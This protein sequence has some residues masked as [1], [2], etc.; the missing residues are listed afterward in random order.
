MSRIYDVK[1]ML[2]GAGMFAVLMATGGE[3]LAA[4]MP[5]SNALQADLVKSEKLTVGLTFAYAPYSYLDEGEPAGFD[6]ETLRLIAKEI[7]LDPAFKNT[8]FSQAILSVKQGNI[9][10]TPGL[11]MTPERAKAVTLV[12]YFS[13]GTAIVV[14]S[15]K[16]NPP[17]SKMDLCGLVVSSIKG[18]AV[19]DKVRTETNPECKE[20]GR[21]TVEV[22]EF[23]TDPGATQALL[24]GAVDAQLTETIIAR[25]V[26][27]KSNGS[28]A[29]SN[30]SALYP[31]Q[32]GWGINKQHK[33]LAKAM[34]SAL[35]RV[36]ESGCEW[37]WKNA[38]IWRRTICP[39]ATTHLFMFRASQTKRKAHGGQKL[40]CP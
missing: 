8:K 26:I 7:D 2:A 29:M 24:S 28:L 36:K 3:T 19:A 10:V 25:T 18:A 22:R 4:G 27:E 31:V 17:K 21:E 32:V 39:L 33:A 13:A 6:V 15:N 34:K 38:H 1:T 37:L 5:T 16:K 9:D 23:S 20:A 12:P 30:E 14:E 40:Q 35:E 11:Y